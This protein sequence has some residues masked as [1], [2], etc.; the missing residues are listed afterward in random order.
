MEMSKTNVLIVDDEIELLDVLK[1]YFEGS[2]H[3]LC[4]CSTGEEAISELEKGKFDVVLTDINL[5]GVDGL[6]VL[7]QA[8]ELDEHASV[9]LITGNA[10]VFNAVEALRKG[11][12]DYITKP[13]N[14]FDLEKVIE[15]ALERRK[16]SEENQ[17]LL[18]DLKAAN[19]ELQRHEENLRQQVALAT[20]RIQTLYEIGKEI[21]SSLNLS[22]TLERIMEKSAELTRSSAGLLLLTKD[23]GESLQ[24][25]LARGPAVS[26][27][28]PL[29][30][31]QLLGGLTRQIVESR[32]P[33]ICNDLAS[34]SDSEPLKSLGAHSALIVPMLQEDEVQGLIVVLDKKTGPF[35]P[36]DEEV[37]TLFASQAAIA[38]HNAGLFEKTMELDRMKSEF[39]AVVSHELRTPLTSIKG[40]LDIL[41]D[42]R[43]F[44]L[45]PQQAELLQIGSANVER[46]EALINDLLDFSKLESS[47]LSTNMDLVDTVSVLKRAVAHLET[48]ASSRSIR[49]A[50]NIPEDLPHL[51]IDEMRITQVVNNL[52][53]NAVKFS[54]EGREVLISAKTAEDGVVVS[55]KDDGVGIAQENLP[56][57][58]QK[59]SQIDSSSTRKTGGTGLGL[60]ISKG[61]VEE[62]G[63]RIWVDSK[64]GEGSTF[65]FRLPYPG[66]DVKANHSQD[67][68]DAGPDDDAADG[69]VHSSAA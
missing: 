19:S 31:I 33:I 46:L 66:S 24:C 67:V 21:T 63:G 53:S 41:G 20:E 13:F 17:R 1:D 56:K 25:R 11:A 5:P 4:L 57:L 38:I 37:L 30:E 39:V 52:V 47:R 7:R 43:Y 55:I 58:F 23:K 15:K 2:S 6:E 51:F 65:S 50:T 10:N 44:Q 22:S 32:T 49:L 12:F 45:P 26:Q 54:D 34:A 69:E 59:F 28:G 9:I 48:L 16:L 42:E 3:E 14:L 61:I 64:E 68:S 27:W 40:S 29:E 8:K 36:S 60:I 62:H 18:E 35:L